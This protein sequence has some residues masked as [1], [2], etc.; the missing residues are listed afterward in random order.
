[1]SAF[2]PIDAGSRVRLARKMAARVAAQ[3]I[4]MNHSATWSPA[5]LIVWHCKSWVTGPSPVMTQTKNATSLSATLTPMGPPPAITP[6]GVACRCGHKDYRIRP[7]RDRTGPPT[8]RL[9]SPSRAARTAECRRAGSKPLRPP[10]RSG[11]SPARYRPSRSPDGSP[12][13]VPSAA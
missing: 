2:L 8:I 1:M 7:D 5:T 13:T 9:L 3:S 6:A 4:A 11:R 12:A 10:Y